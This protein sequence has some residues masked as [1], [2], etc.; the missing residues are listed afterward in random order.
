MRRR[1]VVGTGLVLG[2]S[3]VAAFVA[4]A[5]LAPVLMPPQGDDP[6]IIPKDGTGFTPQPPS[7][8][9]WL[10]TMQDQYDVLYGL[11]WGTRVAFR[12]GLTITL[13]RALIGVTLGLLSGYLRGWFDAL[14]VQIT[15][16]FLA[17]PVLAAVL[18]MVSVFGSV[19]QAG[20][21]RSIR[22]GEDR[23]I[24][25]ALVL[26]GWMQYARLIRGN[27]M[28]EAEK[29]YVNAAVTTGARPRRV[30][31]RHVLPNATQGLW[32][33]VASD[34]GAMVTTVAALTFLGLT[35]PQ[36]S[37]DWGMM[38]KFARNWIVVGADNAFAYWYTYVPA[39]V[40]IVAFSA[41][42]NLVG[43]GLRT[44]LDPRQYAVSARN[45]RS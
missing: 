43:D 12:V 6:Y 13:G 40:A 41:A 35:A 28:V 38:L 33:L 8:A 1:P 42:W 19:V 34:I 26:F 30:L 23:V 14:V 24:H 16:G 15:D 21:A 2:L 31:F 7:P 25:L 4:W 39:V 5:V 44:T 18:V 11:V 37:A 32:V 29:E 10:G 36:P 17:F 20:Q 22:F 45:T 27:V 9:H 3:I